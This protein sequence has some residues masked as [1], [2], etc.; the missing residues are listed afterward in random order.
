MSLIDISIANEH[1]ERWSA[2]VLIRDFRLNNN[3]KPFHA[4]GKNLKNGLPWGLSVG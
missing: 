2:S 1:I 3:E 4:L